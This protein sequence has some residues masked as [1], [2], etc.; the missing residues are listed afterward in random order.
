MLEY[1]RNIHLPG[2][3]WFRS[4]N[5]N[6][7]DGFPDQHRLDE[8]IGERVVGRENWM[9]R[10]QEPMKKFRGWREPGVEADFRQ[11]PWRAI[12]FI[13]HATIVPRGVGQMLSK[14]KIFLGETANVLPPYSNGDLVSRGRSQQRIL[15]RRPIG[16]GAVDAEDGPFGAPLPSFASVQAF[17]QKESKATKKAGHRKRR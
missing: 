17:L 7:L 3:A 16:R 11:V 8:F 12:Y 13:F 14:R 15:L 5:V 10:P 1:E 6:E 4:A 2:A 9:A